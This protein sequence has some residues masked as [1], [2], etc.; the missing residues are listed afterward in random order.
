VTLPPGLEAAPLVAAAKERGVAILPGT[1][2]K[3]NGGEDALR[4]AYSA[5]TPAQIEEGVARIGEAAQSL[6]GAGVS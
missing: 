6:D 4:L 2:F 1:D 5:V 3:L